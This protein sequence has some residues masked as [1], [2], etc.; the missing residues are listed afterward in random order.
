M[1]YMENLKLPASSAFNESCLYYSHH[2]SA[3]PPA[4]RHINISQHAVQPGYV[5]ELDNNICNNTS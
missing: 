1:V 2:H 4:L 5:V 3:I